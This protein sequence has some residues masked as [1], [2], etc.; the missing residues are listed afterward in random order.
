ME[1]KSRIGRPK[2]PDK[3]YYRRYITKE[4]ADIL[5][6]V[7]ENGRVEVDIVRAFKP[8][9][10]SIGIAVLHSKSANGEIFSYDELKAFNLKAAETEDRLTKEVSRL[11]DLNLKISRM[12]DDQRFNALL[13]KYD[14]LKARCSGNGE[15]DQTTT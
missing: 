9:D 5:D 6:E 4:S 11:Q 7:L 2:G 12:S 3:I 15:Y 10:E 13:W 14:Q 8:K 1:T